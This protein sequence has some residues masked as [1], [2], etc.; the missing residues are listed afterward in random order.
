[1]DSGCIYFQGI[2]AGGPPDSQT[3]IYRY[4]ED[5]SCKICM[6]M[7]KDFSGRELMK[8]SVVIANFRLVDC[9][10]V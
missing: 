7:G 3:G 8:P 10:P 2:F 9:G 6:H 4:A 1:M 5:G